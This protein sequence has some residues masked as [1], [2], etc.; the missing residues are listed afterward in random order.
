MNNS[1]Q[2]IKQLILE[3]MKKGAYIF[4][5]IT[6]FIAL[7]FY[8]IAINDTE[9]MQGVIMGPLFSGVAV[10]VGMGMSCFGTAVSLGATRKQFLQEYIKLA[11]I[12]TTIMVGLLN[13][14]YLIT[15]ILYVNNILQ[16]QFYQTG[17]LITSDYQVFVYFLSDLLFG[18]FIVGVVL[19]M[20]SIYSQVGGF[21]FM[22]GLTIITVIGTMSI[23][24][25]GFGEFI[26]RVIDIN[27]VFLLCGLGVIG[28]MSVGISYVILKDLPLRNLPGVKVNKQ[29]N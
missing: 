11:F 17:M 21:K 24:V 20:V 27:K 5:G 10:I 26:T 18:Y 22:V 3:D 1:T 29:N 8:T 15:N 6:L 7:I 9:V 23:Y 12:V 2:G 4:G 19:L 28:I 16:L 14:I 13:V 25:R